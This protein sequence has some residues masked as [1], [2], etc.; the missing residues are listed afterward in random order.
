MPP[1]IIRYPLDPTGSNPDNFV[2]GEAHTLSVR[3]VRAIAP[4]YGAFY[5]ST[6]RIFDPQN[7]NRELVRNIH[8]RVSELYEIPTAKYGQEICA[9][10]LIVD[11]SVGSTVNINYQ[12]LGGDF[13]TA[14]TAIVHM[15]ETVALDNRPV[16]WP[17]LMHVPEEFPPTMHLHDA[18]DLY[19]FEYLVH[20]IERLTNVIQFGD[21]ISHEKFYT[22]VD[23][24]VGD[25]GLGN[26]DELYFLSQI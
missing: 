3:T 8:Y 24:K 7:G 16:A 1:V 21:A 17:N 15:L 6:L 25:S 11:E 23:Q 5:T 12:A 9:I 18:G 10:I 22:Y 20:A 26:Q 2:Q 13:S 4:T 19:G 14:A